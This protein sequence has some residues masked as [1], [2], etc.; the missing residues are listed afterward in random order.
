L[1]RT[2]RLEF[3]EQG[4][5]RTQRCLDEHDIKLQ[6]NIEAFCARQ[7]REKPNLSG[8]SDCVVV[9]DD[10]TLEVF[11]IAGTQFVPDVPLL[12]IKPGPQ[13]KKVTEV[14][15]QRLND[16]MCDRGFRGQEA[17]IHIAANE[18]GESRCPNWEKVLTQVG[19]KPADRWLVR[20]K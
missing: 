3:V 13:A 8:Y 17:L 5:I 14:L 16:V 10:E 19:G 2:R 9:F 4:G 7:L 15:V 20:V 1:I 12:R 6:E 18:P 11:A